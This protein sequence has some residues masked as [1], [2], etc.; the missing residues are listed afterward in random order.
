[1]PPIQVY[2]KSPIN[3]S[4]ASGV[5][6]QTAAPDEPATNPPTT[7]TSS[8]HQPPSNN[9]NPI[10]TRT[11]PILNSGP[12]PPQPGAVPRLPEATATATATASNLNTINNS[13]NGPAPPAPTAA[14]SG[15][16]IP[17]VNLPPQMAIPPPPRAFAAG[18]S[19]NQRGTS[20]ATTQPMGT[21][22]NSG[23]AAGYSPAAS[24][25]PG[26]YQQNT[27]A[28][29]G[30]VAPAYQEGGGGGGG[31]GYEEE[32]EEGFLGSAKKFAKAAGERLS[33]AE[34]EVWKRINGEEK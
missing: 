23:T 18:G 2:T 17:G 1:M 4:K 21:G 24:L 5:T 15:I 31:G 7:T 25:G 27:A 29:S 6:P 13:S 8:P 32:D 11:T 28:V 20:T 22:S 14:P 10:P 9:N 34:S 19:H 26:G 12:P 3:A 33:A 30:F 16:P